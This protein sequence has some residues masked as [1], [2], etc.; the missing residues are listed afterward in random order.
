MSTQ[1]QYR[2]G[3]ATENNAFTGALAEITVD[4]TNWS[5]R[6]HNGAT[7]GG[8]GNIATV[9]Y[10]TAQLAALSANSITDGTSNVKVYNSAN[11]A[12]SV[13]GTANVVIFKSTGANVTGTLDVSG[14][15]TGGNLVTAG[16]ISATGNVSGGNL[17]VTGNIVDSGALTIITGASG[18][19]NL[20][21]NGTNVLVATT[22]GANIAGTLNVTGDVTVGGNLIDTGALDIS[23]GSNG[24]ITL[25]PNGSG[26]IVANK[27]IRNGQANGIGNIG[28]SGAT[29][30]TIFAKATSAQYADLAEMYQGDQSYMPGTVVEFGG[31]NEITITTTE[32]STRIAGVVSTNPSYLMN[33]GLATLNSVPV[34]LIG[35]VPCQVLGPVCKGDR[36]VSSVLPGVAQ[37]LDETTYRP[38]CMI[39]KSLEDWSE[40]TVKLIEVVVG[41]L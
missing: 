31:T 18:N 28:A 25:S 36:L 2:R 24:N 14:N 7:A 26:V 16:L 37:A 38:G 23:T 9:A 3:T 1:V 6:V 13:A 27:D 41:R 30:N 5:L 20:A 15:I 8:A 22:T 35:R 40:S 11:I 12:V 33:S 21:P 39:G 17:N 4:T 29:F 19:V 34:A 10:V 32:S